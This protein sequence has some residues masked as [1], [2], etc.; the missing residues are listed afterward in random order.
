MHLTIHRRASRWLATL[1]LIALIAL[2]G[3]RTPTVTAPTPTTI[4]PTATTVPQ[5]TA[6]PTTFVS[7]LS[8]PTT[9]V[10]P[11]PTPTSTS[12]SGVGTGEPIELVIL[13]SNDTWGYTLPCG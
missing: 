1:V 9:F 3:C 12:Q 2:A 4:A 8:T 13:H 7:P 10:S 5:A 6:T 11:L